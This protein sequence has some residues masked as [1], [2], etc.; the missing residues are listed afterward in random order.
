MLIHRALF[1][2]FI[3][4]CS[5]F[6][7]AEEVKVITIEVAPWAFQ[8]DGE[9]VGIF[10]DILNEVEA[11]SGYRMKK[12]LTPFGF[13]RIY[14]ELDSGRAD[15]TIVIMNEK[16]S[17]NYFLGAKLFDHSMGV[18]LHSSLSLEVYEDL[19]GLTLSA[20]KEILFSEG[21]YKDKRIKKEFDSSYEIGIKKIAKKRVDGMVGAVSTINYLAS[22]MGLSDALGEPMVL[23][24]EPVHLQCSNKS[25]K[26]KVIYDINKAIETI[27]ENGVLSAILKKYV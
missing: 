6:L 12:S 1:F 18:F 13:S 21:F 24:K 10:S 2:I 3:Y 7:Y 20:H 22:N 8:K 14:K 9:V 16:K 26:A 23:V 4:A 19:L 15:C 5:F 27:R 25:K 11:L 17:D